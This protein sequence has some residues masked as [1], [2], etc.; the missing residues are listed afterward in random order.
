MTVR[1][2][3]GGVHDNQGVGGLQEQ[4]CTVLLVSDASGQ[5]PVQEDPAAGIMGVPLRANSI[6]QARVREAQY[7]EL[8]SRRRSALLRD[9]VFV[10]MKRDLDESPVDW[11]DCQD[12]HEA[13]D[14][15]TPRERRGPLT[16]FGVRKDV[17]ARLAAIR[18]DLDSF[19]DAEAHALMVS[20]YR[21][22]E[23]E[24]ADRLKIATEP[25]GLREDWRFL[26]IEDAMRQ[27]DPGLMQVLAA[28]RCT[29]FKIWRLS[30][31]LQRTAVALGLAAGAAL[32]W[33]GWANWNRAL[34]TVAVRQ[35]VPAALI[36]LLILLLGKV[37]IRGSRIG[38]ALGRAVL[39]FF[40]IVC[41]WFFAWLHLLVFDRLYLRWGRRVL[42]P[43]RTVPAAPSRGRTRRA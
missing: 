10:H 38:D 17:Q 32:V 19:C 6:L 42:E 26:E 16:R 18:T 14:E 8:E 35:L 1:L 7:R 30:P 34:P 2:V 23:H 11:I 33:L 31:A 37:A 4:D 36:G 24:L 12:P 43:R 5:M 25:Q 20:A 41:G 22:M 29:G 13:S 39:A 27:G 9:V 28:G 21:M 40:L 15:A 3:D